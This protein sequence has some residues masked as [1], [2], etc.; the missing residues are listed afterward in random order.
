MSWR[1]PRSMPRSAAF[2][3]IAS[4]SPSRVRS[5]TPRR[6]ST[7]AARSTRSSVPSGSTTRR[8]SERACSSSS[9]SN[10]IGVTPVGAGHRDALEQLGGVHVPLEQAE[11]GL[12]LA[13]RGRV[14]LAL[15]GEQLGRR[16][17]RCCPATETTGVPGASRAASVRI[18]PAGTLVQGEQH[19]GDRRGAGAVRGQRAD[20]QVGPVARGDDQ[21]A[22]GQRA[23]GSSA[24]SPRRRRS[25]GRRGRARSRRRGAPSAPRAWLICATVGAE[26]AGSSG[27]T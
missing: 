15:Q 6:S 10:I 9:C 13:R 21:A 17:G 18:S 22:R 11:R 8:L 27:S 24:A 25:R 12:R 5:H 23:R 2:L 14:Q 7:S 3:R 19:A 4:S 1:S 20:D 26:S 16:W